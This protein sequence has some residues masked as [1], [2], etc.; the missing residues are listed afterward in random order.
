MKTI[1]KLSLLVAALAGFGTSAGLADDQQLQNR[2][3]L[4]R[5][6]AERDQKSTTVAVYAGRHGFGQRSAMQDTS[7]NLRFEW[8]MNAKGEAF[9]IYVPVK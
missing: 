7:T 9:G 8:R 5:L 3:S 1:T 2:L 6:A 4:Q